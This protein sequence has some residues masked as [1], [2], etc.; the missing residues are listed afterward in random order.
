MQSYLTPNSLVFSRNREL[1]SGTIVQIDENCYKIIDACKTV[2]PI[3]ES[4]FNN[5]ETSFRLKTRELI[6]SQDFHSKFVNDCGTHTIQRAF[7]D[8]HIILQYFFVNVEERYTERLMAC[9]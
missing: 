3:L 7:L 4:V 6:K 5:Y 8:S 1:Y 2:V 9:F